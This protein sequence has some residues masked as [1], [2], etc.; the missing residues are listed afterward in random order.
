MT[1]QLVIHI[2]SPCACAIAILFSFCFED[3]HFN[4]GPAAHFPRTMILYPVQQNQKAL[5]CDSCRLWVHYKCCGINDSDYSRYQQL[6]IFPLC[7]VHELPFH[8]C[9]FW[10]VLLIVI[11]YSGVLV[12]IVQYTSLQNQGVTLCIA[13]LDCCS[14]VPHKYDVFTMFIKAQLDILETWINDTV[15]SFGSHDFLFDLCR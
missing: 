7:L 10:P 9:C 6:V 15:R 4:P 3:F 8:N 13:H 1:L 14:L 12:M 5:Q 2:Y 11:M